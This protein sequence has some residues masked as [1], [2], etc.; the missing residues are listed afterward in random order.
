MVIKELYPCIVWGAECVGIWNEVVLILAIKNKKENSLFFFL[1]D[2]YFCTISFLVVLTFA[3]H[4]FRCWTYVSEWFECCIHQPQFALLIFSDTWGN[5]WTPL[6]CT[7]H[8]HFRDTQWDILRNGLKRLEPMT[9][10]TNLCFIIKG[11]YS[12]HMSFFPQKIEK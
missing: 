2:T 4:F 7:N 6:Y 9:F 8:H 3:Q 1:W 10:N 5:N 12:L 11:T